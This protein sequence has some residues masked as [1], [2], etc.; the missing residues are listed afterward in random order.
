MKKT[1]I[2][3][4]LILSALILAASFADAK[5][6]TQKP[7]RYDEI[8]V[9][10]ISQLPDPAEPGSYVD[11]RFKFDNNGSGEAKNMEVE[12][13]PEYPFS[14]EQGAEKVKNLGTIQGMQRGD[15]GVIAKFRLRVDKDA[16]EGENEI[17]LRYRI[18]KGAWVD[19]GEFFIDVQTHDAILSI[20]SVSI[21][22]NM[23]EPGASDN[24]KIELSNMADSLLKDVQLRLV[25]GGL[26]FIPLDSTDEKSIYKIDPKSSQEVN[27]RLLANPE[28]KAGVYQVPMEVGYSDN[29]GKK[30]FKNA[31]IGI[32]VGSSPE[33]R[34]TIDE[35]E[36]Y[37][38]GKSG[39][40][41]I[42]IV[43][44]GVTDI[45]FATLRIMPSEDYKILSAD[46]I[47]L[48]NIDSDDFETADFKI[49][50]SNTKKDDINVPLTLEY[51]DANNKEYKENVNL[52][53]K[54]Y[55]SSEAKKFGLKA[56]NGFVGNLIILLIVAVGL[57]YYIR[58]R[59]K[60]RKD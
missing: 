37:E 35:S 28:A 31:T 29:L 25:L 11:V 14:L 58:H 44:R 36:I 15:I 3:G 55:S 41:I 4:L 49:Y 12:I 21:G 59:K 19:P 48:G 7:A 16:V 10:L 51:R 8:A 32:I 57:L 2:V 34:L 43:N 6:T 53:L 45:K 30:Y 20:D 27:F 47:Y 1:T 24:L 23:I 17:R 5:Q 9:N 60:K 13:L 38:K 26:P 22:K 40:V 46:Q 56:G 33:L 50:A 54:I 18:D 39:E 42:K 52:T